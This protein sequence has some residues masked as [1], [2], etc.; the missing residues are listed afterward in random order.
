MYN[1]RFRFEPK[2]HSNEFIAK[3]TALID[4]LMAALVENGLIIDGW[5]IGTVTQSGFEYIVSAYDMHSLED[6]SFSAHTRVCLTQLGKM[7]ASLP[8]LEYVGVNSDLEG[9]CL[10]EKPSHLTLYADFDADTSPVICGS[11]GK[12]FPLRRFRLGRKFEDFAELLAWQR[13]Y[14]AVRLQYTSALGE[15]FSY[16]MLHRPDSQLS[17]TGRVLAQKLEEASGVLTYY[18]ILGAREGNR[19]YCPVCGRPWVAPY[20][21]AL[22]FTHCCQSCRLV[23]SNPVYEE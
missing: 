6:D 18:Y 22:G 13:L 19:D 16:M 8:S 20:P 5:R 12:G 4:E 10:C 14:K 3:Y 17:A 21:E 23:S 11:C 2:Q 7:S 9:S 15:A 1:Y